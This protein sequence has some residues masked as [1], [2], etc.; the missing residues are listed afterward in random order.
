MHNGLIAFCTEDTLHVITVMMT[1]NSYNIYTNISKYRATIYYQSN[2]L[3]QCTVKWL[4][5]GST[6]IPWGNNYKYVSIYTRTVKNELFRVT[7]MRTL[8]YGCR[9]YHQLLPQTTSL[10]FILSALYHKRLKGLRPLVCLHVTRK[11]T[12]KQSSK[13][14][15]PPL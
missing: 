14:C 2:A 9:S 8:S 1:A 12:Q 3:P 15:Y 4:S 13:S 10:N 11:I 5:Y 7:S 6:L